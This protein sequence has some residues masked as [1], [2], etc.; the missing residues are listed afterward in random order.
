MQSMREIAWWFSVALAAAAVGC[1]ARAQP[2]D[3]LPVVVLH[4]FAGADGATPRTSLL[5]VG[6]DF[7]GTTSSGGLWGWGTIFRISRTG[8]FTSLYSFLGLGDGGRPEGLV[9]GPDGAIYG[10]TQAIQRTGQPD[11]WGTFFRIA[12]S[13]ALTTLF[14]FRGLQDGYRPG[15]VTLAHDGFFYGWTAT[16]GA[17]GHGTAFRVS[18]NGDLTVVR[19]FTS[20]DNGGFPSY[21]PVM[22]GAFLEGSD[23]NLYAEV[24]NNVYKMTLSGDLAPVPQVA[25]IGVVLSLM[26]GRDGRFYGTTFGGFPCDKPYLFSFSPSGALFGPVALYNPAGCGDFSV[27]LQAA[28]GTLFGVYT[29]RGGNI[30]VLHLTSQGVITEPNNFPPFTSF[31]LLT[32]GGD[33]NIYGVMVGDFVGDLGSIFK[34]SFLGVPRPPT[35]V[36]LTPG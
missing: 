13:G 27:S 20:A 26:S 6:D 8:T 17:N 2:P 5:A 30:L 23:G 18:T 36:R 19:A 9:L 21:I 1:V 11:I 28:D 32:D 33:G 31:P 14:V 12:P 25:S 24:Q 16:G 35:N 15:P 4:A 22:Q 34:M 3:V 7:Y 29:G 10:T